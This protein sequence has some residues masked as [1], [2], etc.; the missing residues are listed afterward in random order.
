M[1]QELALLAQTA[2]TTMV[3][4]MATDAWQR[5]R[6]RVVGVWRRVHPAQADGVASSLDEV[7]DELLAARERGDEA[8]ESALATEWSGRLG[9]L[10]IAD[11]AAGQQLAQILDELRR[12]L[13]DPL[14]EQAPAVTMSARVSGHGRVYQA[15]RDQHITER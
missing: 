8:M 4:L 15:G 1:D 12:Q 13:P 10:L 2:S 14:L 9:R 5:A 7:R 3:T 11:P 6:D